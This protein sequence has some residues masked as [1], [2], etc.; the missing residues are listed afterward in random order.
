MDE[1]L[2]LCQGGEVD[3]DGAKL[4]IMCWRDMARLSGT[5]LG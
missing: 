5:S 1:G 3:G 2:D 4:E